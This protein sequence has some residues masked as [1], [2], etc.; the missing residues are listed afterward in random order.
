MKKTNLHKRVFYKFE[1][2]TISAPDVNDTWT[3]D[4]VDLNSEQSGHSGY[5]MN[6]V[7]IVSRYAQATPIKSKNTETVK[8]GLIEI[9]RLFGNKT[10][11]K[12]WCDME[13]A[14]VSLKDWL[15]SEYQI[16]LYHTN[17]SYLGTGSHSVSIVERFNQSMD[18]KMWE[19]QAEEQPMNMKQLIHF[20][21]KKFIPYYN[22]KIHSTIKMTPE[23]AYNGAFKENL[24]EDQRERVNEVK[25]EPKILLKVG[26]RVH[27]QNKKEV[28]QGK[29]K[30]KYSKKIYTITGIKQTN[31]T[32]YTISDF[33]ETGF[34][35]QQF[36]L[37]SEAANVELADDTE[38]ESEAEE[39][40]KKMSPR[41]SARFRKVLK[42]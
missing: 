40:V 26:D 5:I 22:S 21:V 37:A 31:P 11:K 3:L 39:P 18:M 30:P 13:S 19:Y 32:T 41:R 15:L 27:V 24:L 23:D 29:T 25:K 20:T 28:I 33:G 2:K 35:K 4:L 16:E 36:I 34:Y 14:I 6:V 10:P 17:N 8:N 12:L 7:D 42:N 38:L 9:I 1:R